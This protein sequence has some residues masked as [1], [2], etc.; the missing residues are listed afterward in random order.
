MPDVL[1]TFGVPKL[2]DVNDGEGMIFYEHGRHSANSG[3]AASGDVTGAIGVGLSCNIEIRV[4]DWVVESAET[5]GGYCWA[6][7][8]GAK[9]K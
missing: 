7:R 5:S 9:R 3:P 8:V 4:S 6:D 1:H 2:L